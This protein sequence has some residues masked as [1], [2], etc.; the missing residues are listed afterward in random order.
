M[1]KITLPLHLH[2]ELQGHISTLVADF[3]DFRKQEVEGGVLGNSI[4]W[5]HTKDLLLSP[6]QNAAAGCVRTPIILY[7]NVMPGV[8]RS[9]WQYFWTCGADLQQGTACL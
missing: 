2:Y 3:K 1:K 6:S 4:P 7:Y 5:V 9:C 8:L